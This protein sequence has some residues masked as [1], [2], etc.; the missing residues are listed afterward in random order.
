MVDQQLQRRGIYDSAVLTAMRTVSRHEFV[1]PEDLEQAYGDH[2]LSIGYEQT[3][4]QPYI[5]ASMT[6]EL[7]IS[8]TSRVLEIGTGCGY[9]TAVLAEICE[10]VYTVEYIPELL[11]NASDRLKRLGYSNVTFRVGDGS[12][13]WT[14]HAP[15]DDILVAAATAE[16]PPALIEQLA[17]PGR[18]VIPVGAHMCDQ[19]LMLVEKKATKITFNELYGVRFVPL[20]TSHIN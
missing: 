3:I 18:M 2:P 4:S 15:F 9:Q 16:I 7:R 5:V 14:E 1:L 11:T 20:R 13:G 12:L 19:Q 6:Q 17:D 10:H 8:K